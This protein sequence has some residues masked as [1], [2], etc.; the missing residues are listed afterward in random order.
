MNLQVLVGLLEQAGLLRQAPAQDPE[1]SDIA[2][3]SREVT[4]GSAFFAL[5]G[6]VTDGH[7]YVAAAEAAGAVAIFASRPVSTELPLVVV[8]NGQLAAEL[9]A[10][11]W[12]GNPAT[13]IELIAVT[14]TNGK[15]TTT[16]LV[17]HLLNGRA[18]VGS[19]GTIGA[20]D[21]DDKPV[22]SSAG[23][24]TTPGPLDL[25]RTF[26]AMRDRGVKRIVMEA[27]SHALDQ[28]RL[29]GVRFVGAAFTN[30]TR[31]HLDYH[32]DMNAYLAAK[33]KLATL[34]HD[35][36]VLS[37]NASDPGWQSLLTDHRALTWGV[38]TAAD[39]TIGDVHSLTLG[40]RFT[41]AGKFGQAE[42]TFPIPGDFNLGNAAAAAA[43][44][45]GL[46]VSF[47]EVIARLATAPQVPGRMERLASAP[48]H[49]IRDYAH[50]PDALER[51]L[52]ALRPI[53]PGRIIL[54]FGCGG[55]RDRGKRPIMGAVAAA[56]ADVV[57]VTSDN[58]RTEDPDKIIDDII[59]GMPASGWQRESD[60]FLG[61][62]TALGQGRPG[63]V[64][65]LAGKGHETYQVVGTERLPFDERDIV[66]GLL[67]L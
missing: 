63:D 34:V 11:S 41:M 6:S 47:G 32:G 35:D 48:F 5:A 15:T 51:M 22:P 29:D 16:A 31:D 61:I 42:G 46:G 14:G 64:V 25:H 49:V 9:V 56:G 38:G 55:D 12:F 45:L 57:M 24:L 26:A 37:I 20:F 33:L 23:M 3:D 17:R 65:V 43:L 44:A 39:V 52:A 53:T 28:G 8:T 50:T 27:S 10:A 19:I 7:S 66:R 21:G 4:P 40:S 30:L 36:G 2:F 60:R 59:A 62:A 18:D 67:G 1:I 58:P 13:G 54:V